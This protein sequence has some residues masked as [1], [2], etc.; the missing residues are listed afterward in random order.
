M[1]KQCSSQN[2][3]CSPSPLRHD[4]LLPAQP[5]VAHPGISPQCPVSPPCHKAAA[6]RGCGPWDIS[7]PSD[8]HR[9]PWDGDVPRKW[10]PGGCACRQPRANRVAAASQ[11]SSHVAAIGG[12]AGV[13]AHEARELPPRVCFVRRHS[14]V[15]MRATRCCSSN[16]ICR[17]FGATNQVRMTVEMSW[18]WGGRVYGGRR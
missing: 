4:S 11:Q 5:C 3:I 17:M 14:L 9:D 7:S 13:V 2:C 10:D 1:A 15:P 18:R 8:L 12:I 6:K 16:C